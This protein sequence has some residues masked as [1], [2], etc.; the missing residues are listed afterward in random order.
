MT[1]VAP[2]VMIWTHLQWCCGMLLNLF[3]MVFTSI[4]FLTSPHG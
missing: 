1:H 3:A 4:M 2:F